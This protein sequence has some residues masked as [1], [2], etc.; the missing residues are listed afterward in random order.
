LETGLKQDR[1][2]AVWKQQMRRLLCKAI[3]QKIRLL[4]CKNGITCICHSG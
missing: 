4:Q 1:S 3:Q 2:N